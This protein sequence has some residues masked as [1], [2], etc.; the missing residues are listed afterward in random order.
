LQA[1][2]K[3]GTVLGEPRRHGEFAAAEAVR[4]PYLPHELG[5]AVL[6]FEIFIDINIADVDQVIR[7]YA[8]LHNDASSI[9]YDLG[10]RSRRNG[11][12]SEMFMVTPQDGNAPNSLRW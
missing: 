12:I 8:A 1:V 9:K 6:P 7:V 2:L 3:R 4:I 10:F 5:D 11:S